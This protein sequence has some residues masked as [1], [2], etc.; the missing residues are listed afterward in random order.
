MTPKRIAAPGG[1]FAPQQRL[2]RHHV[3]TQFGDPGALQAHPPTGAV[4]GGDPDGGPVRAE[5][6]KRARR[7]GRHRRVP[8]HGVGNAGVDPQR[9]GGHQAHRTRCV[10]IGVEQRR[11]RHVDG[12]HADPLGHT[13]HLGDRGERKRKVH[14]H[15]AERRSRACGT[16]IRHGKTPRLSKLSKGARA[17]RLPDQDLKAN[18]SAG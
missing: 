15:F 7:A 1:L 2:E 5:L 10:D 16:R 11:V 18:T 3:L 13:R 4:A 12:V 6:R 9:G 14:A 8:G 17:R